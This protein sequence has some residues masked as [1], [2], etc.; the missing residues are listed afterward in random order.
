MRQTIGNKSLQQRQP[1]PIFPIGH[2]FPSLVSGFFDDCP[3]SRREYCNNYASD[4]AIVSPTFTIR[5]SAFTWRC[6]SS[7]SNSRGVPVNTE[8]V[9]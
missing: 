9:P 8:N 3:H 4:S 6:F 5:S 2:F 1:I 7:R